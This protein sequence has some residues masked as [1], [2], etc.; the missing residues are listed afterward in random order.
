MGNGMTQPSSARCG[1]ALP[2]TLALVL[3]LLAVLACGGGGSGGSGAVDDML[4]LLPRDA[5]VALYLDVPTLYDDDDLRPI[6]RN[7]EDEWEDTGFEDDFDIE[8]EDLAYVVY[9]ETGG[10]DLFLFG[11]LEDLDD[12]RDELDDQDYED[13]DIRDVEVWIDTSRRWEAFAFLDGGRV[14][15]ADDEDTMED[16]LRRMDRDSSSLYDEVEDIVSDVPGGQIVVVTSCGSDCLGAT[17]LEKVSADEMKF[18]LVALYEDED[19]AEDEEDDLKDDIEDDDI[20]RDCDDADVDRS[21]QVVTLEMVCEVDFFRYFVNFDYI[22]APAP[23]PAPPATPAPLPAA[24]PAPA[25]TATP[26]P[27]PAVMPTSAPL[28]AATPAPAVIP[29]HAATPAPTSTPL[30]GPTPVPPWAATPTPAT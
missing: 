27:L 19:D 12:L 15:V 25:P 2:M 1:K 26:A 13:D 17:S 9:G 16:V 5:G 24:T 6:R 3:A 28:P 8:L 30:P 11:G 22:A 29:A 14:L 4:R 7:A 20:P 21:G 10:Y 23:I 18:V